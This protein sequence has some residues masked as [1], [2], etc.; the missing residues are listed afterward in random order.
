MAVGLPT[1]VKIRWDALLE[2]LQTLL[3]VQG[4]IFLLPLILVGGWRLKRNPLIWAG[5][6][7]WVLTF[8]AMTFIFPLAGSR[9]GFLHSGAAF[10]PLFWTA[11]AEGLAGF[12]MFGVK[13]RHWKFQ[14]AL[15]G[16]GILC[17]FV[18]GIVTFGLT[19]ARIAPGNGWASA[20]DTYL[21]VDD[22]MNGRSVPHDEVVMVN[23]P[24][25]FFVATGRPAVV[26]PNGDI[27]TVLAVAKKYH[28]RFLV[29]ESNTVR[30]LRSLYQAPVD[31]PGLKVSGERRPDTHFRDPGSMN[32]LHS[33]RNWLI[34]VVATGFSLS[35][36]L[37]VS[38]ATLKLGFPLDDA[39]IHQ[40]YARN[41]ATLG[42]WAFLPGKVSAGSTSPLWSLIISIGYFLHLNPLTWTYIS[43]WFALCS[44]TYAGDRL[45]RILLVKN[46]LRF[47]WIGLFLALE[48]HLV[49]AAGSGMETGLHAFLILVVFLMLV[50]EKI[51]ALA[52]GLVC[53]LTV[54]VR[55][56]GLTLIGPAVMVL[57]LSKMAWQKIFSKVFRL[58]TGVLVCLIPYLV[59]NFASGGNWWPNT[60]FAKQAEYAILLEEPFLVR[61]GQ[62]ISQPMIGAGLLIAPGFL[63]L[64]WESWNKRRWVVL[65]AAIWWLGYT[66]VY[67]VSLPVTYQHARYLIP[68]MPVFYVLGGTGTYLLIQKMSSSVRSRLV[69]FAWISTIIL[70]LVAFW[71]QGALTYGE[72]VAIIESEMV[73]VGHWIASNT[74][75][76]SLIAAHDIG[77]IGYYGNRK[78]LDLAGLISPEVIPFIRDE[79]RLAEYLDEQ[80]ADYLVTFPQWYPLLTSMAKPVFQ[81]QGKFSII[82]GGENMS[83]FQ[84]RAISLSKKR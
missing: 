57:V 84:W 80:G 45:S 52:V 30:D 44:L 3:A 49:W 77:A 31:L 34:L 25:G 22:A 12:V 6:I 79:S 72:D 41:L 1:L 7:A 48:W 27:D 78:M 39:W 54:W 82:A 19:V 66:F 47:P 81:T 70:V 11:A 60:F 16:F 74:P 58:M 13:W 20:T 21:A 67:A 75:P 15:I 68:A 69:R 73:T 8:L 35:V 43:G 14:R 62:L 29:L 10:Q 64:V 23:N 56:D 24:P 26:I 28:V 18:A 46:S 50:E 71:I 65:A 38:Q 51:P 61:I 42:E 33:N 17:V 55:P 63:Y 36:Y 4:G 53:G 37:L 40:T 2:N 76:D 83:V 9:G 32:R 5:L 59:F